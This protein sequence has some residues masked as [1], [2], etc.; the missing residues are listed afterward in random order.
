MSHA[1]VVKEAVLRSNGGARLQQAASESGDTMLERAPTRPTKSPQK[2]WGLSYE[3][4]F[5]ALNRGR[6]A[7]TLQKV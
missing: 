2:A 4:V 7:P 6:V 5:A 3:E 1:A